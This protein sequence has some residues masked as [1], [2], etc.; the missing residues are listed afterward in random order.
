[1][2]SITKYLKNII[3]AWAEARLAYISRNRK[4]YPMGS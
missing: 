3:E 4:S 2:K 1:M